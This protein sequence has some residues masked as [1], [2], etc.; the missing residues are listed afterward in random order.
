MNERISEHQTLLS[1]GDEQEN[2]AHV[3]ERAP[4]P[5]NNA[6]RHGALSG[7]FDAVW[8]RPRH[9]GGAS[10][11]KSPIS[12]LSRSQSPEEA[13]LLYSSSEDLTSTPRQSAQ[14]KG[15]GKGRQRRE[16]SRFSENQQ[17]I[18]DWNSRSN[19]GKPITYL[20]MAVLS[21][22]L[23][24]VAP[25]LAKIL[26]EGISHDQYCV[27]SIYYSYN[28]LSFAGSHETFWESTCRNPVKVAS[29]FAS[30]KTYCSPAEIAPGFRLID[31]YCHKDGLE[32][33]DLGPIAA[34]MT[35]EYISSLRVVD[36]EEISRTTELTEPVL[37]SLSYF[38][39]A[40]RTVSTWYWEKWTH[41]AY[42]LAFYGFWAG[43]LLCGIASN[44][45]YSLSGHRAV[46]RS[47]DIE[48]RG[49]QPKRNPNRFLAPV[50]HFSHYFRTYIS[51]PAAFGQYHQ[52]LLW[53]C[54][55]PTRWETIVVFSFWT[56]AVVLSCISY[57]PFT[58]NML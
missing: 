19:P 5:Q 4:L 37:L 15:K 30:A 26:Y 47:S 10:G 38:E 55:I 48:G 46:R 14:G 27:Y 42:G 22:L 25:L 57:E 35:E 33:L 56:L 6:A 34:N 20:W 24:A 8:R 54:T 45:W 36:F 3:D 51:V 44:A 41:H 43:I 18:P 50:Y 1:P 28:Y 11:G 52:R 13:P 49:I 12:L 7:Y 23:V 32:L 53:W 58:G 21:S 29:M 2:L 16:S 40:F 31:E 17:L 39:K 9:Q